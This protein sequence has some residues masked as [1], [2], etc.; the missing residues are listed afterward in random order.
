MGDETALLAALT[1]AVR[2][3]PAGPP[4]GDLVVVRRG[5]RRRSTIYFV[6]ADQG[7]DTTPSIVVK[8]PSPEVVRLGIRPPMTAEEQYEAVQRLHDFL[9]GSDTRFAAPRGVALLPEFEAL[10]M[11]FVQGRSVWELV[12]PSAIWHQHELRQG[13]R[14]GG[15]ALRQ[16]PLIEPAES[17]PADLAEV[18]RTAF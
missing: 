8:C 14:S 9:E 2:A 4:P 17:A 3:G 10:A 16:R 18:E 13:V 5:L 6:G 15:L 7:E 1:T 12:R 11:E